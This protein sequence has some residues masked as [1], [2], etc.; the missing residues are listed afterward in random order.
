MGTALGGEEA[1]KLLIR[2]DGFGAPAVVLMSL[3]C[4]AE[5]LR[6]SIHTRPMARLFALEHSHLIICARSSS[7]G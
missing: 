6:F 7:A 5:V 2:A 1:V 4:A 3:F